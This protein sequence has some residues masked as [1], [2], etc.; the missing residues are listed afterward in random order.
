MI[1]LLVGAIFI[2]ASSGLVVW[3]TKYDPTYPERKRRDWAV[4]IGLFAAGYVLFLSNKYFMKGVGMTPVGRGFQVGRWAYNGRRA[5][6][7]LNRAQGMTQTDS[8]QR[9]V[10]ILTVCTIAAFAWSALEEAYLWPQKINKKRSASAKSATVVSVVA[11]RDDPKSLLDVTFSFKDANGKDQRC[12]VQGLQPTDPGATG[13]KWPPS[14]GDVWPQPMRYDPTN[15]TDATPRPPLV[16]W[17]DVGII[18]ALT[19]ALAGKAYHAHQA[20]QMQ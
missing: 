15:P 13:A 3:P 9:L 7:Y 14:A 17:R 6:G 18:G 5:L 1:P 2:A 19:A 8:A 20:A 12:E 10:Q 16:R 11:N 4:V